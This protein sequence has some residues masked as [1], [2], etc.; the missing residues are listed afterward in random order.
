MSIIHVYMYGILES[1]A[2]CINTGELSI[3]QICAAV[4][5]LKQAIIICVPFGP[6]ENPISSEGQGEVDLAAANVPGLK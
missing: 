1:N 5:I 3:G 4:V 2:P 6:V